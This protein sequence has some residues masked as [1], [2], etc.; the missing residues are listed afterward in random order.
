MVRAAVEAAVSATVTAL[1]QQ[2][3]VQ[4]RPQER[5]RP[6]VA[7]VLAGDAPR[8]LMPP[9]GDLRARSPG[10][11]GDPP[12]ALEDQLGKKHK[13]DKEQ[14]SVNVEDEACFNAADHVAECGADLFQE[15]LS[16]QF[17]EGRGLKNEVIRVNGK[18]DVLPPVPSFPKLAEDDDDDFKN[19]IK[20]IN[21]KGV[22]VGL[23][24]P[25]VPGGC[26]VFAI[27]GDDDDQDFHKGGECE[28][29]DGWHRWHLEEDPEEED[30]FSIVRKMNQEVFDKTERVS[31]ERRALVRLSSDEVIGV[32]NGKGAVLLP[33]PSEDEVIGVNG[34]GARLLP[35]P[36]FPKLAENDDFKNGIGKEKK[37][38]KEK[39]LGLPPEVGSGS[40]TEG[41]KQDSAVG[42]KNGSE[43]NDVRVQRALAILKD[44]LDMLAM[45]GEDEEFE[46][47]ISKEAFKWVQVCE[48]LGVDLTEE[49]FKKIG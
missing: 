34:K 26:G 24:T 33:S 36:S 25:A 30:A 31:A 7:P 14:V 19:G 46:K 13:V 47:V 44:L 22:D 37:V 1:L 2:S 4:A 12:L 48:H 42:F 9:P 23:P 21:G 49:G 16:L 45:H 3:P 32:I 40:V 38:E 18:G 41:T 5:P 29:L 28:N 39:G 10:R 20:K 6:S 17:S 15:P 35:V 8:P 43:K 11:G 27:H